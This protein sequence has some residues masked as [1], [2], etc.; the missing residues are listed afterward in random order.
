MATGPPPG[1]VDT[2]M[3]LRVESA[4]AALLS[5]RTS[6]PSVT[7]LRPT[8][9]QRAQS[10]AWPL[11]A[12]LDAWIPAGVTEID[13]RGFASA[14]L[15]GSATVALTAPIE[16]QQGIGDAVFVPAGDARA[17]TFLMKR[18]AIVGLGMRSTSEDIDVSLDGGAGTGLV[19]MPTLTAGWHV[20]VVST[21]PGGGPV[22]IRP[23]LLGRD[24]PDTGPPLDILR[25][26]VLDGET[27]PENA[28]P[29]PP[30]WH[31][32]LGAQKQPSS[33]DGCD[34]CGEASEETSFEEGD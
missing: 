8:G 22:A 28:A 29:I 11:G 19:Q 31:R 14:A 32:W 2:T 21:Q 25:A 5:L 15:S 13:L 12:R 26:Y 1:C 3:T 30:D 7:R 4:G 18:D 17:F 24:E 27:V 6:H 9:G 23:V 34:G 20:L 10:E 33:G 16:M